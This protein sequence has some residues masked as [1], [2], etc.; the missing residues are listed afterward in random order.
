VWRVVIATEQSWRTFPFIPENPLRLNRLLAGHNEREILAA[1]R[2]FAHDHIFR[3]TTKGIHG[4]QAS[5][6]LIGHAFAVDRTACHAS[7]QA[8]T[9]GEPSGHRLLALTFWRK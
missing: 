7:A 1:G 3:R 9:S 4:P 6:F 5:P 2:A 8:F